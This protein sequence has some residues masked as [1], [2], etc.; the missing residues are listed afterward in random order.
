MKPALYSTIAALVML[1]GWTTAAH[2]QTQ[3]PL[4]DYARALKK[5]KSG[6]AKSSKT[7]DNDTMPNK[8]TVNVV[9]ASATDSD[10][11][12]DAATRTNSP[13]EKS[14]SA[15]ER[16]MKA[17]QSTEDR[18]K[19]VDE[20]KQKIDDQ[21]GKVD[22]LSRELDVLQRERQIKQADFYA[23]TARAVQNSRGFDEE[24]AKYKEKIADK[25]KSLDDANAT[26]NELQEDARK[27]GVPSSKRE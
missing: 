18:E 4:G 25:Q 20:W 14:D 15:K 7:Y 1:A 6:S 23:S 16:E 11:N 13:E 2:P 5:T 24:D 26:L 22:L 12:K 27:A 3:Q 19:A 9:G 8:G 10:S 17:G 21:K